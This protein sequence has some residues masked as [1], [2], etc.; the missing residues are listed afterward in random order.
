MAYLAGLSGGLEALCWFKRLQDKL[1]DLFLK[2][3]RQG[4]DFCSCLDRWMQAISQELNLPQVKV[5][6]CLVAVSYLLLGGKAA[7]LTEPYLSQIWT[8]PLPEKV[9][10]WIVSFRAPRM[11][12]LWLQ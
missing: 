10:C 1:V 4:N 2:V 12:W 11:L 5:K 8:V 6:N 3:S 7:C 9:L